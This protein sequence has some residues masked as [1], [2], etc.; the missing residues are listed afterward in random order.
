VCQRTIAKKKKKK[1][2]ACQSESQFANRHRHSSNHCL[3]KRQQNNN[4]VV[5]ILERCLKHNKR[6]C[7]D[8]IFV[9]CAYEQKVLLVLCCLSLN[10]ARCKLC[11]FVLFARCVRLRTCRRADRQR[12]RIERIVAA[13]SRYT[14][15]I[16]KSKFRNNIINS[17]IAE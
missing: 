3:N 17:I 10:S 2:N 12:H 16:E 4:N 14:A 11:V 7:N 1:K 13:D 9:D 15:R 6:T 5:V 8:V